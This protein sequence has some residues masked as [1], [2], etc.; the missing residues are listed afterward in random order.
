VA[1]EIPDDDSA[2]ASGGSD[3]G[4]PPGSADGS[5]DKPFG[6]GTIGGTR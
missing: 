1:A 5:M 2:Y 4:G 3:D 6:Q